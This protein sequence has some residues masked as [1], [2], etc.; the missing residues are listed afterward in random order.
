MIIM[1]SGI[2]FKLY[3]VFRYFSFPFWALFM[4]DALHHAFYLPGAGLVCVILHP[5][6]LELFPPTSSPRL[7]RRDY[8][9]V[10]NRT[11]SK[12]S[13]QLVR[14]FV[15]VRLLRYWLADEV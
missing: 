4:D 15:A 9:A 2:F 13:E 12:I 14:P 1:W 6:L 8:A 10:T 7:P 5:H 3:D 11:G